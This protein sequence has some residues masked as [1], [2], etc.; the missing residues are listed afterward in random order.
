[1]AFI[2]TRELPVIERKP[3][4]H[5]RYF[6]SPRMTFGWYE[7]DEGAVL[8]THD[9]PQEEVWHVL[10]GEL[11]LT[12]GGVTAIAGPGWVGIVPPDTPHAVRVLKAG[13]AIVADHPL[14]EGFGPPP[15]A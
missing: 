14:R 5:G 10:S 9:H 12:I 15:P 6:S 1:M 13:K 8:E 11:E 4:W 2:D 7:F 3:G